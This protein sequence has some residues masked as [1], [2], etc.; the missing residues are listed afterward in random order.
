MFCQWECRLALPLWKTVWNL[1][2]KLK[3][4]LPFDPAIPLLGVCVCIY[5]YLKKTKTLIQKDICTAVV[6]CSTIYNG[7]ISGLYILKCDILHK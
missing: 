1:P 7:R 6:H 3:I 5:I 2:Q 4:E